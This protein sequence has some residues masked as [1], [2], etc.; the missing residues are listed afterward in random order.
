MPQR[1]HP[2]C[3]MQDRPT[4]SSPSPTF[5]QMRE[6]L[7]KKGDLSEAEVAKRMAS[8][9]ALHEGLLL[10]L[11]IANTTAGGVPLAPTMILAW[12]H[13]GWT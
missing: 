7:A 3:L 4:P 13:P 12:Q 10:A 11:N 1:P 8:R 9:V 5:P 2:L 6:A